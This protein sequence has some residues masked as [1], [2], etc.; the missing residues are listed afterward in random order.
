MV[1]YRWLYRRDVVSVL[2]LSI[3]GLVGCE[4]PV[5]LHMA[6]T[7]L[8]GDVDGNGRVDIWDARSLDRSLTSRYFRVPYPASADVSQNSEVDRGDFE[9]IE[10]RAHG[11]S[12]VEITVNHDNQSPVVIGGISSIFVAD[13][14]LPL[15]VKEGNVRI[16]SQA[17]GYDSGECKLY[18][19]ANGRSLVYHWNTAG[20]LPADDYVIHVQ[21]RKVTGATEPEPSDEQSPPTPAGAESQLVTENT[22]PDADAKQKVKSGQAKS[23]LVGSVLSVASATGGDDEIVEPP[24]E[25]TAEASAPDLSSQFEISERKLQVH[26]IARA[27]ELQLLTES[28]DLSL[29]FWNLGLQ[30]ARQYRYSAHADPQITE[31][32]RCWTHAFGLR[33]LE[34]TDGLI[35]VLGAGPGAPRFEK[36][37]EG[38][39]REV[40]GGVAKLVR[41]PDGS[42]QLFLDN[43]HV[44][45]FDVSLKP[46]EI[47]DSQNHRIAIDYEN[48]QLVKV[49]D[50]AG[51]F[52]LFDYENDLIT[53]VTDSV[54]RTVH[55]DYDDDEN[56]VSV[57]GPGNEKTT[58]AYDKQ[59]R[60]I[61]VSQDGVTQR[62]IAYHNDGLVQSIEGDDSIKLKYIVNTVGPGVRSIEKS[63]GV[64]T[65]D[66]SP[67][68]RVLSRNLGPDGKDVVF[69]YDDRFALCKMTGPDNTLW[70]TTREADGTQTR[71][72]L[73]GGAEMTWNKLPEQQATIVTDAN[74]ISTTLRYLENGQI[75]HVQY[76]DG[77][78]EI[79]RYLQADDGT[80]VQCELRSGQTVQYWFDQRG[81]LQATQINRQPRTIYEYDALGNLTS[82]TNDWGTISYDYDAHGYLIACE[83]PDGKAIRY[84]YDSQGRRTSM[85][86]PGGRF[87]YAYNADGNL[88]TI[89][90]VDGPSLAEY[91][92][93]EFGVATRKTSNHVLH[94]FEYD[95]AGHVKS[96][97][98]EAPANQTLAARDYRYDHLGRITSVNTRD[99]QSQS[100]EYDSSG[101]LI[102]VRNGE[103]VVESIGYDALGNRTSMNSQT[104]AANVLNQYSSI[105]DTTRFYDLNGNLNA[106][107]RA[108]Q[109]VAFEH[110]SLNRL[111]RVRLPNQLVV[112]Y[113]Y[114]PLGRLAARIINGQVTRF[115]WDGDQ[116]IHSE[117]DGDGDPRTYVWGIKPGELVA[118]HRDGK[119]YF[120]GQDARGSVTEITDDHGQIVSSLEYDS[121]GNVTVNADTADVAPFRFAG[122]F[123]DPLTNLH[124][125]QNRWYESTSGTFL[126]PNTLAAISGQHPYVFAA[127]DPI[128]WSRRCGDRGGRSG[129]AASNALFDAPDHD[130]MASAVKEKCICRSV[131]LLDSLYSPFP[132][133]QWTMS[134][135]GEMHL[136]QTALLNQLSGFSIWR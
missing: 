104:V 114:D 15:N 93:N 10:K 52:L 28:T 78:V 41:D 128:N 134:T 29:P 38:L 125:I 17:T 44:W 55:F 119:W 77:L 133:S 2:L 45:K 61:R 123:C 31:F 40:A 99:G 120:F 23:K 127:G 85:T 84:E 106:R 1:S 98:S 32:G 81:L 57:V 131:H 112:S 82:A 117:S 124:F 89:G 79:R 39:Y 75:T 20:L 46:V 69:E 97:V 115:Y 118:M 58:Y 66:I 51:Q 91:E 88:L 111:V 73:P 22:V 129:K 95:H 59:H 4:L 108:G 11:L 62:K 24:S 83:Y 54:G 74:G 90:K 107:I 87:V 60:L 14:F 65:E 86:G 116:I 36:S 102:Y 27:R 49:S 26:V 94:K 21:L 105:G 25:Q 6:G 3:L 8:P 53:I 42:F 126:E 72:S 103:D 80:S 68:G 113:Q 110:D 9:A 5:T 96:K 63:S 48:D 34:H 18:H 33:L 70:A 122:A 7:N 101:R 56:L 47:Q 121:F 19:V 136:P 37:E 64:L 135:A 12:T 92:Y 35:E 50:Q 16:T 13:T 109:K 100:Y 30:V 132:S 71:V 76:P 43:D 67:D 130:L